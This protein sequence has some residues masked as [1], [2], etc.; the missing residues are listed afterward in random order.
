MRLG[1][2]VLS[3]LGNCAHHR[4]ITSWHDTGAVPNGSSK[5]AIARAA[6]S[7]DLRML[8]GRC[9]GKVHKVSA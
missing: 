8:A 5:A 2:S 9:G 1:I 6:V 3:L 7:C 4:N